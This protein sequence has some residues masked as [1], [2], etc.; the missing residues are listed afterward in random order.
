MKK[1]LDILAFLFVLANIVVSCVFYFFTDKIAIPAHW[2][3]VGLMTA[4]GQTW[5][6]LV[7]AGLSLLVYILMVV[8]ERHHAVN[9]PFRVKNELQARP[10][11][12]LVI[13]WTNMLVML[14]LLYVDAAVAQYVP[15]K[16]AI[17][18][19]AILVVCIIDFYYTRKIF[20]CGRKG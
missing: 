16:I 14:V 11:I 10:Y 7:L 17:I 2:S 5:L 18:Y 13:A 20:Q 12:D 9:L 6:I 15:M 8:S 3:S 1:L 4:Y 19:A